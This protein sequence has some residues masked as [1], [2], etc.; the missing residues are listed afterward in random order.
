MSVALPP[1][2]R[3]QSPLEAGDLRCAICGGKTPLEVSHRDEVVA[4]VLRCEVCDAAVEYDARLQGVKCAFCDSLMRLERVEDPVEQTEAW[5]PFSVTQTQAEQTLK[6]WLGNQGFFAPSDLK[7]AARL[8][9]LRPLFWVGWTFE[10]RAL[11][12]WT[13]DSDADAGRSAW[14]PHSGQTHMDFDRIV[15]SAS[16]GLSDREAYGLVPHYNLATAGAKPAASDGATFE[17]FDVQRSQARQRILDAVDSVG[18]RMLQQQGHIPGRKYRNV[19]IAALLEGLT[20]RR[21]G[22]PAYVMAYRYND[23]LFRAVVCGQDASRILGKAPKS[24]A[25]IVLV[26]V[27]VA[28]VGLMLLAALA[29]A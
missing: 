21:L 12:S 19:K 11:V 27:F 9:E 29:S 15:V 17:Q 4:D 16:R 13:A 1:C 20:T 25:K 24:L 5:L 7:D 26:V 14:A 8:H 22:F 18:A 6:R 28:V 3:C 10:A 23:K 2:I